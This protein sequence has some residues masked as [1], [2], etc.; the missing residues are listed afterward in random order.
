MHILL[1]RVVHKNIVKKRSDLCCT[2]FIL[3]WN[4]RKSTPICTIHSIY[5]TL[6]PPGK[7]SIYNIIEHSLALPNN[8]FT[9]KWSHFVIF[10]ASMQFGKLFMNASILCEN[11]E[12]GTETIK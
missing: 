12:I 7:Q 10:I 4:L 2:V 11:P 1:C 9:W 3:I 8:K 5:F 6:K